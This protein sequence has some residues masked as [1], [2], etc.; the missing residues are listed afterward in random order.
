[1][2]VGSGCE[3]TCQLLSS[4]VSQN[5]AS[6][7]CIKHVRLLYAL[8]QDCQYLVVG[9]KLYQTIEKWPAL[10]CQWVGL[11]CLE[12][13]PDFGRKLSRQC[14]APC[15]PA[16]PRCQ[17]E[18]LAIRPAIV[19]VGRWYRTLEP[20]KTAKKWFLLFALS[21]SSLVQGPC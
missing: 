3:D 10:R 20:K 21:V 6:C 7:T 1:M 5:R 17:K 19:K 2:T 4:L 9:S 13:R 15:T 18:K 16:S 11:R 8:T 14:T 12:N